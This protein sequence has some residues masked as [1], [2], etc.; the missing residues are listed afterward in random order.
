MRA[1]G[2]PITKSSKDMENHVFLKAKTRE[3]YLS[4]VARLIL[5]FRDI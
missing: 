4:L 3:E 2:T 1:A 5:H